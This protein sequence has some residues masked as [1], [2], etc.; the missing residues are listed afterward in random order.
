[1]HR[2]SVGSAS[3]RT[4]GEWLTDCRFCPVLSIVDRQI[5]P[6]CERIPFNGS[7]ML[8]G[9]PLSCVGLY[10]TD[11][12]FVYLS[13]L[14]EPSFFT[15]YHYK[16]CAERTILLFTII[17][18]ILIEPS[19]YILVPQRIDFEAAR[20]PTLPIIEKRPCFYYHLFPQY[21]CFPPIFL[22]SLR[23]WLLR[24]LKAIRQSVSSLVLTSI[25]HA[26]HRLL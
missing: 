2:A 7:L 23:L 4:M 15:I 25:V 12:W 9:W 14:K 1:M 26:L 19:C 24:C 3:I 5:G 10:P 22:T 6:L 13:V 20:T 8:F 11:G 17:C 18:T 21:F 16:Y